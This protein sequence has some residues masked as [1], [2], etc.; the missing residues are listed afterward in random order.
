M[1]GLR[2]YGDIKSVTSAHSEGGLH[3]TT[4][5]NPQRAD[6]LVTLARD[7]RE[8]MGP[9]NKKPPEC[10]EASGGNSSH[11]ASD[12]ANP[13]F[14]TDQ[15]LHRQR[16]S[17]YSCQL[18]VFNQDGCHPQL[19][20]DS[21]GGDSRDACDNDESLVLLSVTAM[22]QCQLPFTPLAIGVDLQCPSSI[23]GVPAC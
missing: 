13:G 6:G 7:R 22:R 10:M 14:T 2:G 12:G 19:P 9:R 15:E 3:S 20:T 8:A 23:S 17:P 11:R 4:A 1:A 5:A 16:R 21:R 18:T